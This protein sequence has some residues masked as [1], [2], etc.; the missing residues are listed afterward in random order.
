MQSN[1]PKTTEA[2]RL[3]RRRAN[4]RRYDAANT[5][6]SK[7]RYRKNKAHIKQVQTLYKI[8]NREGI[9]LKQKIYNDTVRKSK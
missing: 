6:K 8:L 2:E 1:K 7:A 4:Q 3:E 5:D 9:L